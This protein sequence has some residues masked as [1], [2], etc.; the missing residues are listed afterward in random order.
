MK[1]GRGLDVETSDAVLSVLAFG[2]TCVA[3]FNY[4]TSV[5]GGAIVAG[6]GAVLT[7]AF[8]LLH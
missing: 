7:F 5:Y 1:L 8:V 6:I 4:V 3:A 2:L